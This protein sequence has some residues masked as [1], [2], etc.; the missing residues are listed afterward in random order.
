MPIVKTTYKDQVVD[1][2][3]GLLLDGVLS[4]GDQLKETLLAEQMGISRAPIRE[5]MKELIMNGLVDYRPQ[6]GNFVPILSPKQ[7]VDSYTTRGVLEGY[8]VMESCTK[9]S[10]EEIDRLDHFLDQMEIYA[11]KNNHKMVVETGGEFHDLLISKSDNIQLL[12]Y[13]DRLSLKLH[14]LFFKNWSKLYS[15]IE[16][17]QR[18]RTILE[19]VKL[20][21]RPLIETVIRQHYA[22]TGAKIAA[23]Q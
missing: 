19:S 18:H 21:D 7:I 3:Y 4:P 15:P 13:T 12:E 14:V 9:F 8:A 17:G 1:Y 20:Q 2:V 22:E 23:L 10:P 16:I 11:H 6:V 5:A